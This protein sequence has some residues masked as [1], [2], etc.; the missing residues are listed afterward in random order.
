[1]IL[2]AFESNNSVTHMNVSSNEEKIS[3]VG[4]QDEIDSIGNMSTLGAEDE[5]DG[6]KK[7][8]KMNIDSMKEKFETKL[9]IRYKRFH[10]D[11]YVNIIKDHPDIQRLNKEKQEIEQKC[12]KLKNND[13][14]KQELVKLELDELRSKLENIENNIQKIKNSIKT[15]MRKAWKSEEKKL[16]ENFNQD[17]ADRKEKYIADLAQYMPK[18]KNELSEEE[19]E[20]CNRYISR[21]ISQQKD[22][23]QNLQIPNITTTYQNNKEILDQQYKQAYREIR[24]HYLPNKKLLELEFVKPDQTP[25]KLDNIRDAIQ[26]L[27]TEQEEKEK[28][29]K[30][31]YYQH[32]KYIQNNRSLQQVQEQLVI[33]TYLPQLTINDS[34]MRKTSKPTLCSNDGEM[35]RN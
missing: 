7:I 34:L 3:T 6:I 35:S 4:A 14:S 8:Y 22:K 25:E 17:L 1:M 19:K 23:K 28:E 12:I 21:Y 30:T 20:E 15:N 31:Q 33:Y 27:L 29:I 32:L 13:N 18:Y 5:I 10:D 9:G 16:K 26:N 2:K 24:E 11:N